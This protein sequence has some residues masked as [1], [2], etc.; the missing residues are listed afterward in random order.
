VRTP[1]LLSRTLALLLLA[2][3]ALAGELDG[4]GTVVFDPSPPPGDLCGQ[5]FRCDGDYLAFLTRAVRHSAPWS[6]A[7][8]DAELQRVLRDKMLDRT[9]LIL[10]EDLRA[11]DLRAH[12]LE[13]LN[14]GF[15]FDGL[16][17]APLTFRVL[18]EQIRSTHIEVDLLLHDPWVGHFS[19][20]LLLPL[21]EGPHPVV[22]G[23]PG[24]GD[25][26]TSFLAKHH[27]DAIVQAGI[28]V[29][30]LDLRV[31]SGGP[32]E[33]ALARRF[34]GAGFSL[35]GLHVYEAFLAR[36]FLRAHPAI[37]PSRIGL[38]GHS[39]GAMV[40]DVSTHLDPDWAALAT[41][42]VSTFFEVQDDNGF[43]LCETLPS[44]YPVHPQLEKLAVAVPLGRFEYGYPEGRDAVLEFLIGSLLPKDPAGSAVP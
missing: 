43:V 30:A 25:Y 29:L 2:S 6:E 42:F 8:V 20:V 4:A 26:A 40:A 27:G 36:K 28:A 1:T 10:D 19:A 32:T 3:P 31:D 17:A 9:N 23:L 13:E 18:R 41:D 35:F 34:L 37:D 11:D 22:V 21:S 33:D 5:P 24:H 12:L 38:M 14:L 16:D 44:L 7:E 39:G 15:L